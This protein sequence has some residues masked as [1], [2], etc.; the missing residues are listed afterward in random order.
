[1]LKKRSR[2]KRKHAPKPAPAFVVRAP[3]EDEARYNL[4]DLGVCTSDGL[5]LP[6]QAMQEVGH[7]TQTL[8]AFLRFTSDGARETFVN[9]P[10]IARVACLPVSTVRKHIIKL[11][12]AELLDDYGRQQLNGDRGRKRRT[13]TYGIN[14][15]K[16]T[17]EYKEPFAILPR[18]AAASSSCWSVAAVF[19]LLC[20]RHSLIETFEESG[21][22]D[23]R[24]VYPLSKLCEQSGLR[25]ET[26]L[27]AKAVLSEAGAIVID[28]GSRYGQRVADEIRMNC[29]FIIPAGI[30][31]PSFQT[32]PTENDAD[33]T[34]WHLVEGFVH[35]RGISEASAVVSHCRGIGLRPNDI[36][37]LSQ[38][39]TGKHPKG[40]PGALF[41][42]YMG[43]TTGKV[44]MFLKN[45]P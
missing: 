10:R 36:R 32:E 16:F 11:G 27:K 18:W 8:A 2:R 21:C 29:E 37:R 14:P 5:L 39:W 23:D 1:M 41:L 25:R 35:T 6:H 26:V 33:E 28:R 4:H 44:E 7:A 13:V 15:D 3:Y 17:D 43:L 20:S 12:D 34:D 9:V 45:I 22:L 42:F 30:L 38:W 40:A 19:A 31:G 24:H